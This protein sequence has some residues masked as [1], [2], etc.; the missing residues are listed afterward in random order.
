MSEIKLKP[1]P[2]C[3]GDAEFVAVITGTDG[4]GELTGKYKIRC[5]KCGGSGSIHPFWCF[6]RFLYVDN[7]EEEQKAIDAWNTRTIK[8]D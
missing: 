2:F 6:V 4:D 7:S 8:E 5:K 1:C 3:G